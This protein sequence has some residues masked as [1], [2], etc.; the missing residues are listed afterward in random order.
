MP[1]YS[2]KTIEAIKARLSV[3]D[4]VSAYT[5]I[6]NRSGQPWIKCPFHGGGNERTPSCK[7]NVERGSYYCFGCH[8]SGSM[9]DFVMKMDHVTFPDSIRILA[10]KAGVEVE[11]AS[12]GDRIRKDTKDTLFELNERICKSF[13]Y[14]LLNDNRP[15]VQA[16]RDYIKKRGI[17]EETSERFQLGYALKD[18]HWLYNFLK[19]KSYTDE[20]L[21]EA[22]FFSKNKYPYPLFANRLMFPV[23]S[24]QGKVI[25]FGARDLSFRDDSPKYINTP[26]T[27][28][29]SKKHNLYGFYEALP[30]VK[31][32]NY[33]IICEGNFDAISLQ[34]AGL[35]TAVAPFGT[36]FTSEQADLISR[37]ANKV[38]LLFDSDNAGIQ[39][40]SKA[41]L[42][43]QDK[44]LDV[45]VLKIEGAKD[46]SE[47]LEKDGPEALKNML[48]HGVTGFNYLV[49]NGLNL[50][51]IRTPKGKSDFVSYL[52]PF[53][54]VT[55]SQVERDAYVQRISEIIGIGEEQ[56]ATDVLKA[57]Q[58][59][60]QPVKSFS[61]EDR[62][63]IIPLN[64]SSISL[65]LYMM[66]MFANHRELFPAYTRHLSFGDIRDKEAQ[67]IFVALENVR[68]EEVGKTD[69]VFLS[70]FADEQTR[71]D[72]ATS[73][74][75]SQFKVEDPRKVIDEILDRISL[76]KM[77]ENRT[78]ISQQLR[79]GE[80]EGLG[81][82]DLQELLNE[83]FSLDKD[84][85]ALK[86]RLQG[87]EDSVDDR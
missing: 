65:D 75:L 67:M 33:V 60:R 4:V 72:V 64:P 3:V 34:Q 54:N 23:R 2:D 47:L 41:I 30:A 87:Q 35:E 62:K 50:Y 82:E 58:N 12:E 53:L 55:K 81:D 22:G 68:R 8:E 83:K 44:G 25:A 61:E 40:T 20:F 1:R 39:A 78:L 10:E 56:V 84:I 26:E 46:A 85:A 19:S 57:T 49:T 73:F 36:A 9:F 42:M 11:E 70:F 14:I 37:Y 52:T 51:N 48:N 71:S 7:L 77:E 17:S 66:L 28:V 86:S 24:W 45:E 69:E 29:Y 38:K 13:R 6:F 16:A 18:T 79:Q 21:K 27:I 43:L 74:E 80:Q 5:Q 32:N 15:E 59:K 63:K 76:R 31:K